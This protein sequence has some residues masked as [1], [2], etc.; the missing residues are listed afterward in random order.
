MANKLRFPEKPAATIPLTLLG[1]AAHYSQGPGWIDRL[2]Q[3]PKN[4]AV[5]SATDAAAVLVT[6]AL[7]ATA[8]RFFIGLPALLGEQRVFRDPS[9]GFCLGSKFA[10]VARCGS[11]PIRVRPCYSDPPIARLHDRC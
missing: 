3:G 5:L 6:S 8:R 2:E 7:R 10:E 1:R 9:F 4:G 11:R